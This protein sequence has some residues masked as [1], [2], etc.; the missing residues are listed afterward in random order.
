MTITDEPVRPGAPASRAE[1][2]DRLDRQAG[3]L[4][5]AGLAAAAFLSD[6]LDRPLFLEGEPGVG[7]TSFAAAMATVL[8]SRLVRL[9]CHGG[10][11]AAQAL[12]DWNF[13]QQVLT[14]RALGDGDHTDRVPSLWTRDFLIARPIL[15]ALENGPAV[16]L[17]DEIDRADDEF[18]ALLLQVLESY[19]IDI[20]DLDQKKIKAV[21]RPFVILTSNRTRDVHDAIKR[22]CLYHWI[23]H[24][25]E[26]REV[27]ILLRR[28]AGL[29]TSLA[30]QIAAAMARLREIP[31]LCKC[32]G[33]AESIDL[34]RALHELECTDLTDDAK[35]EAALGTVAKHHDDEAIVRNLLLPKQR[36][37][38]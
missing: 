9:Q 29:G 36:E 12:Y 27:D 3:Y 2:L 4:A 20:P 11:D 37:H 26:K 35:V 38:E 25:K 6:R 10:I 22:R 19:E 1:L 13:P 23:D 21:H 14:L 33:V 30:K 16:L 31:G 15:D 7:K 32:P 18:E 5:D 24:P 8:G 17:V 34:A 28:V